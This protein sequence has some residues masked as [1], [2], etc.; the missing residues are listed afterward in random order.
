MSGRLSV[1]SPS[2]SK[3]RASSRRRPLSDRS[4]SEINES[5]QQTPKSGSAEDEGQ[6]NLVRAARRTDD[7]VY[8]TSPFPLLESQVF[9]PRPVPSATQPARTH[10][11]EL[12]IDAQ[13]VQYNFNLPATNTP[14]RQ[15]HT[16]AASHYKSS[17]PSD[18]E[19]SRSSYL[20]PSA[21]PQFYDG[22]G[23]DH[24]LTTPSST[25][26][27]VENDTPTSTGYSANATEVSFVRDM[28]SQGTASPTQRYTPSPDWP[29][30]SLPLP[31]SIDPTTPTRIT[32]GAK[33][34]LRAITNLASEATATPGS[35]RSANSSGTQV[36][37]RTRNDDLDLPDGSYLHFADGRSRRSISDPEFASS[38]PAVQAFH[39]SSPA[40]ESP[41]FT[42]IGQGRRAPLPTF[43]P[44]VLTSHKL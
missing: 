10:L 33:P 23:V 13:N 34:T 17:S 29:L 6:E 44:S 27:V 5:R 32:M 4:D 22:F 11:N 26:R 42:P 15:Q 2:P 39:N 40:T 41:D 31:T 19:G 20:A 12:G 35:A 3:S 16:Y 36:H 24:G 38:S 1:E 8:N 14:Q 37:R 25:I 43:A 30:P 21:Y 28:S 7:K 18:D 9:R